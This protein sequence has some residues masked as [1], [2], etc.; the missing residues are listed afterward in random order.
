MPATVV[1]H[2]SCG[3]KGASEHQAS[4]DCLLVVLLN[5]CDSIG[6]IAI[7]RAGSGH[8]FCDVWRLPPRS[9]SDNLSTTPALPLR[10]QLADRVVRRQHTEVV[11]LDLQRTVEAGAKIFQGDCRCQF[12]DLFGTEQRLNF[13]EYGIGNIGWRVGHAFGVA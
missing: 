1:R 11:T 8:L 13:R 6:V 7:T 9:L 10:A 3:R 12:D 2:G 4:L 5:D